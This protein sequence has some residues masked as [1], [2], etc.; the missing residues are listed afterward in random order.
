MLRSLADL[1]V[2]GKR[3]LLRAGF[4][5]PLN[6]DGSV[7]NDKRIRESLPTLR[8]LQERGARTIILTHLGRPEGTPNN[9]LRTEGVA[10][11]LSALLGVT[12]AYVPDT[13]GAQARAAVEALQPGAVLMLENVRFDPREEANDPAFAQELAALAD[14]YV[15]DAFSVCHRAHASI[16]G[17]PALLP[18]AMGL[19]VEHELQVLGQ[20]TEHP[21][22][23]LAVILGG[24]KLETRLPL[25]QNM[26]RRV[27]A[28]KVLLGGAM[29]FPFLCAQGFSSGATVCS[30]KDIEAAR[31]LVDAHPDRLVLPLDFLAASSLENVTDIQTVLAE[32]IPAQL[33][34]F[35]TGPATLQQFRAVLA[36]MHTVIWNGPM[37]VFE[38]PAF[39]TGTETLARTLT[40][41]P[42]KTIIGGG[43]TASALEQMGL[44]EKMTFVSTGGGA[45]LTFLEGS[46]LPGIQALQRAA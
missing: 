37:G 14:V 29:A 40:E 24:V 27:G 12:V 10:R 38:N 16:V 22:H 1:P 17:V 28:E 41:L 32:A 33:Y 30:P 42:A 18:S 36:N 15:N 13:V 44:A 23:P 4:D 5:V 46:A 25:I 11:K 26:L 20:V 31:A 43:D 35:D 45:T 19:R 34:A 2:E 21:D 8:A 7:A 9:A 39:R 6:S 3:V